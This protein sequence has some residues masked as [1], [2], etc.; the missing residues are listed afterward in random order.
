[1]GGA[2]AAAGAGLRGLTDRLA[3]AGGTL[4]VE[5]PEGGGT[6]VRARVPLTA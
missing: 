1:M 6:R 2:S 3:A 4:E 5:S